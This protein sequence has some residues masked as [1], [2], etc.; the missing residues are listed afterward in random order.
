M[1]RTEYG[2]NSIIL[3][4][5]EVVRNDVNVGNQLLVGLGVCIPLMSPTFKAFC[6]VISGVGILFS[7]FILA[8]SFG[9]R[10]KGFYCLAGVF[11]VPG[12]RRNATLV[13]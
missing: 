13:P 7:V 11:P 12:E 10:I 2:C 5:K 4:F 9:S 6:E 8:G 3:E 1:N